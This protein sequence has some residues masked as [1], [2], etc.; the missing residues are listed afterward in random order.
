MPLHSSLGNKSKTLVS[1][2]KKKES[3]YIHFP[4][5]CYRNIQKNQLGVVAGAYNPTRRLRQENRLNLGGRACSELRLLHCIPA[6][7]TRVKLSLKT[8]KT[9]K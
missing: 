9:N 2:K 8:N 4:R 7:G 5:Q 6:W 1:K 3:R